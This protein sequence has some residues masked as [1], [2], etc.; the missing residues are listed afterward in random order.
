MVVTCRNNVRTRQLLPLQ[1]VKLSRRSL[2]HTHTFFA[3][4]KHGNETVKIFP[5]LPKKYG[6]FNKKLDTRKNPPPKKTTNKQTPKEQQKLIRGVRNTCTK[7]CR[8]N[9]GEKVAPLENVFRR[10]FPYLNLARK[11]EK[12]NQKI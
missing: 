3:G 4:Q 10:N 8:A 11:K 12:E 5:S 7:R 2:A 6:V 9:V 1:I